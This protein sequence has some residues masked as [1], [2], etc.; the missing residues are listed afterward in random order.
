MTGAALLAASAALHAGAGRVLVSLLDPAETAE[1]STQ[2]E[3]ML[4]RFEALELEALTIVCGCGGGQA[5]RG[6]L[7][8]VLQRAG[9]LVLDADALNALGAE[10][11]LQQVL[12]ARAARQHTTVLTPTRWKPHACCTPTPPRCKPT[13]WLQRSNSPVN[14]SVWWLSKAQ[15]PS[16]PPPGHPHHQPHGQCPPGNGGHRR[17]LGR[18]DWCLSG[19]RHASNRRPW[20]PSLSMGKQQT[21]GQSKCR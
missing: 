16:S 14:F 18:H 12:K 2:P 19:T 11:S 20:P 8:A 9:T 6:V 1:I 13:G 4:R 5:V 3:L 10:G 17:C 21:S 15:A 7:P